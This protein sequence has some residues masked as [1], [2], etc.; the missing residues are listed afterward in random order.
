MTQNGK[1]SEFKYANHE[2]Y[3][4]V[5]DLLTRKRKEMNRKIQRLSST[6]KET[7]HSEVVQESM[8]TLNSNSIEETENFS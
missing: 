4:Q 5:I 1:T 6:S 7:T 2:R 8:Q 3:Q